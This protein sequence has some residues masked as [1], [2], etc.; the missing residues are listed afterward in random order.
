VSSAPTSVD[1]S[2][3]A[4]F[5]FLAFSP[6]WRK[7]L[8]HVVIGTTPLVAAIL[9]D[10]PLCPTAATFGIPCPGCGLT[11]ATLAAL[12]GHFAEA[13]HLHP[14]FFFVTPLYL[15][16]IGSLG[17]TYVRGGGY[18]PGRRWNQIVTVLALIA[19]ALLLG[20][21]IARFLG[22]FG[23]PVSVEKL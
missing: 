14:L 11:R 10:L 21:W 13:F 22:A 1:Q 18:L 20:V 3:P 6:G 9:V 12:H 5:G 17:Y 23:G 16:V 7:R 4:S 19:F 8:L 15:G 2:L